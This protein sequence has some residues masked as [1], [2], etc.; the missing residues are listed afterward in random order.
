MALTSLFGGIALANAG[1]GAVHGFAG[2]IG[3][4]IG[5]AHGTICGT[6]LMPV[7]RANAV[8]APEGSVAQQRI[9]WVMEQIVR[10]F[11]H[12]EDFQNWIRAHGLPTINALGITA[13][14]HAS[15]ARDAVRSSSYRANPV[16][17]QDEMLLHVLAES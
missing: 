17:L 13:E 4:Q 16:D 12:V 14:L 15:I 5:A 7:L 2:V 8:A 11:G 10:E 6:L 3:G 9:A 1:L